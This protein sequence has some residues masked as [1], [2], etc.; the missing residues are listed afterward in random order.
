M[1][2]VQ[3]CCRTFMVFGRSTREQHRQDLM[4]VDGGSSTIHI[5][6]CVQILIGSGCLHAEFGRGA[7]TECSDSVRERRR[8][9]GLFVLVLKNMLTQPSEECVSVPTGEDRFISCLPTNLK[10]E[11]SGSL[12]C[13]GALA[14]ASFDWL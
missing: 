6:L 2:P 3:L 10:K 11:E 14:S 13:L 4:K 1:L 8:K 7:T 12:L 9:S 5:Q